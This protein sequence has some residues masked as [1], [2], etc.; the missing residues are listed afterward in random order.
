VIL[1]AS[2]P[3][4][5]PIN[6]P[7]ILPLKVSLRPTQNYNL[8]AIVVSK[9]PSQEHETEAL[10]S[11]VIPIDSIKLDPDEVDKI[12]EQSH[13][14]DGFINELKPTDTIDETAPHSKIKA[15]DKYQVKASVSDCVPLNEHE[16]EASVSDIHAES[17]VYIPG[18]VYQL[19]PQQGWKTEP[20]LSNIGALQ[21]YELESST[22]GIYA[23]NS[24]ELDSMDMSY[25]YPDND[26]ALDNEDPLPEAD[27]VPKK[28]WNY[29]ALNPKLSA[30]DDK[31]LSAPKAEINAFQTT[32]ELEQKLLRA[33]YSNAGVKSYFDVMGKITAA[34]SLGGFLKTPASDTADKFHENARE[35]DSSIKNTRREIGLWDPEWGNE[36]PI[37]DK[38][39]EDEPDG[40]SMFHEAVDKLPRLLE[41]FKVSGEDVAYQNGVKAKENQGE[42]AANPFWTFAEEDS[43]AETAKASYKPP[44][45]LDAAQLEEAKAIIKQ[46]E[47]TEEVLA[48]EENRKKLSAKDV[49]GIGYPGEHNNYDKLFQVIDGRERTGLNAFKMKPW[50]KPLMPKLR[51]DSEEYWKRVG[52]PDRPN[53]RRSGI[54]EIMLRGPDFMSNQFDAFLLYDPLGEIED[55]MGETEKQR[56]D[57]EE[58]IKTADLRE[59]DSIYLQSKI[60]SSTG[61]AVRFASVSIPLPVNEDATTPFLE[62]SVPM[63]KS[64]ISMKNQASFSFDLDENLWWLERFHRVS[65][66]NVSHNKSIRLGSH[67]LVRAFNSKGNNDYESLGSDP[68][69]LLNAIADMAPK[70]SKRG[71]QS[72]GLC[73]VIK[74]QRLSNW[75]D[76]NTQPLEL[77]WF[78]FEDVKFLGTGNLKYE[79]SGAGNNIQ[80][81]V[82]FTFRRV[83]KTRAIRASD[84]F[85]AGDVNSWGGELKNIPVEKRMIPVGIDLSSGNSSELMW[86]SVTT[87]PTQ[88]A[89]NIKD[90][91]E[92]LKGFEK[93]MKEGLPII[94]ERNFGEKVVELK[95][96][97]ET[98][99]AKCEEEQRNAYEAFYGLL[100]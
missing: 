5:R 71:Y 79:R 45:V 19:N 70:S 59:E 32:D 12:P 31:N 10:D 47:L 33:F 52:L 61:F 46:W 100:R 22:S 92:H 17:D 88:F 75:F 72:M 21:T 60:L 67:A 29:K 58:R 41:D 39:T 38:D 51:L 77:P 57:R 1:N 9:I 96:G 18:T 97:L 91:L 81:T 89:L 28:G 84:D 87:A 74:M 16:K 49:S 48:A 7:N 13:D 85:K 3:T 69:Y 43:S 94:Y 65:G 24:I 40:A 26:A 20:L 99:I 82:D 25:V 44:K 37:N 86:L 98:W 6:N 56:R 50:E 90:A 68:R 55:K 53:N 62:R 23:S 78:V 54:Q 34:M 15:N 42:L 14:I 64:T 63:L 95:S 30:K 2:V 80:T 36:S 83:T 8:D 35:L 66:H 76:M 4:K 73:L 93:R 27:F 11:K